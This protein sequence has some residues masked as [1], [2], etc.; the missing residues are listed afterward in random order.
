MP[1]GGPRPGAGR[2]RGSKT[3]KTSAIAKGVAES[4]LAPIEYLLAT[5]RNATLEL[6]VRMAA[7]V[8]AAPY[9][10]PRLSS[11]ALNLTDLSDEEL[12]AA[13]R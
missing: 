6:S 13:A 5:M 2:P 1:R 12:R 4:G 9:C 3:R 10:H 8:A 7:A 11:V